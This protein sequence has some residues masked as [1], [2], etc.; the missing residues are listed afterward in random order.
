MISSMLPT[1]TGRERIIELLKD[2]P[3]MKKKISLLRYELEHPVKLSPEEMIEAMSF[4]KGSGET[5]SSGTV[6][7]KTL[8]I[9]MNYQ[10]E[11]DKLRTEAAEE[12]ISRLIALEQTVNKLE[13]YIGLLPEEEQ[14]MVRLYYFEHKPLLDLVDY[15]NVS[16]WS[17]RKLRD[18]AVEHL[19]QMYD[20][21]Q[22][23]ENEG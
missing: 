4:A 11:A 6:S 15:F 5:H 3:R 7:N 19:A 18:N 13:Y 9:A 2:Y 23:G 17:V 22:G 10:Q 14:E 12:I 1:D 21:V 16:I 8:Y 20:Y